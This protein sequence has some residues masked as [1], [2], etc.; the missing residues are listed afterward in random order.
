MRT[1]IHRDANGTVTGNTY[2]KYG[3]KNPVARILMRGFERGLDALW[4]RAAPDSILDIGCGEGVWTQR[5][6]QRLPSGRVVGMDLDSP[7]L[8]EEWARRSAPN[9]EF[10]V[11]PEGPL[12]FADGE[13]DMVSAIEVLE[14]VADPAAL[15]AELARVGHRQL[16]VSVPREP[17]WRMLNMLR[18]AYLSDLGNTPGHINHW[19]RRTFV[20]LLASFG[21]VEEVL[22][23][24]PWTM[25]LVRLPQAR[26]S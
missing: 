11:R 8:R 12:P 3:S 26:R 18:G 25:A 20:S 16:L 23:P 21:E 2:D 6:A 17:L 13:F 9:L 1:T 24:L 5:W 19:S 15:L 4:A 7:Q 22:T 14:H 10:Q